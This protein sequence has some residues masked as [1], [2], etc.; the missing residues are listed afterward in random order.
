MSIRITVV[1]LHS[2]NNPRELQTQVF[3]YTL[4]LI[5]D[6]SITTAPPGFGPGEGGRA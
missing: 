5:D 2:E 1:G 3:W 4:N 6:I